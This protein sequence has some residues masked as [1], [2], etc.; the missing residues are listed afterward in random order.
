MLKWLETASGNGT[1]GMICLQKSGNR[2]AMRIKMTGWMK[3][4]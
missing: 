4:G 1:T 3:A 2:K